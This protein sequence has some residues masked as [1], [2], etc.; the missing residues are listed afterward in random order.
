MG[1]VQHT[2]VSTDRRVHAATTLTN[3][4]FDGGRAD[5]SKTLSADPLFQVTHSFSLGSSQ[6]PPSYNF[7]SV[8]ATDSVRGM[9]L[10]RTCVS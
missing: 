3:L 5:L 7:A 6:V 1:N 2:G 10:R 9:P 4:M 8:Y